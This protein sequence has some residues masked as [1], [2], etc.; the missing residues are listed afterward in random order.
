M[1]ETEYRQLER[2]E[3]EFMRKI[4]KTTKGCPI[5][6]LY[7]ELGQIPARF[8]IIKMRLLY[9]RYILEQPEKSS[10]RKMLKLQLENPTKGDWAST[11]LSD[12]QY[13][14]W[15]ITLEEIRSMSKQNVLK[16]LKEK[17]GTKALKYLLEKQGKKGSE[18]K[19]SCIEMAEY[20]LPF[21][22]QTNIEQKREMFSVRNRMVNIPANFSS[23]SE[24]TCKC[25]KREDLPHIYE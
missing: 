18:I 24:K 3:E 15:N 8:E 9:L 7:L 12:L 16:I 5:T 6:N 13:I 20:L 14:N 10:I 25:G 2:I 11:C 4:F 21:N 1:K 19:Y 17:I 23:Q 22:N